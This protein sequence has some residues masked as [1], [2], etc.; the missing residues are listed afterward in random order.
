MSKVFIIGNGFD[1]N[2]GRETRYSDFA[3]SNYWKQDYAFSGLQRHLEHQKEKQTNGPI[4]K[5]RCL[6]MPRRI[7]IEDIHCHL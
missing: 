5:N 4:W 2:L 6:N 1:L 7:P 3:K